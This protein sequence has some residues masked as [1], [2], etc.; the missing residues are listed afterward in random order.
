MRAQQQRSSF[1]EPSLARLLILWWVAWLTLNR[2]ERFTILMKDM[3]P[4]IPLEAHCVD[5]LYICLSLG[6][7]FSI[8]Q[9]LWNDFYSSGGAVD[10]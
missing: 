1:D 10:G 9:G 5:G 7:I 6:T 4:S 2:F 8:F 3:S